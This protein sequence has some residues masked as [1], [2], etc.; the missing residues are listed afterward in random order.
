[1][2]QIRF[3]EKTYNTDSLD[4]SLWKRILG[5]LSSQKKRLI[6]LGILNVFIALVDVLLPFMNKIGIDV[7]ANGKGT[8]TQFY[9]FVAIFIFGAL[10]QA[11][12]VY[13]YFIEAG[14]TEMNMAYELR[15][16]L[17]K[18]LQS[19]SYSYFDVTPDGWLLSRLTSDVTRLSEILAWSLM[20]M[21]WGFCM[22]LGIVV[23]MLWTNWRLALLVL[24]VVPILDV[25]ARWFNIRI[26]KNYRD[27]RRINSQITSSFNEGITGAKTT[28]TLVLEDSNFQEFDQI[29]TEMKIKSIRAATLSAM[30]YP[31]VMMLSSFSI[32]A[33]LVYGGHQVLL[34]VIE[35]GTLIMFSDYATRFF[36]PLNQIS[37]LIAEL[38]MA[39]ASAERVLSLLDEEPSIVD[40]EDV[41][42]KYGNEFNLKT[43]N[44]EKMEGNI[45]FKNVGFHYVEGQEVLKDFNLTVKP[46]EM[47]ALVGETGSGKSTIV[48]LLCRFYEPTSG[49]ILIDGKDYKDRSLGWLHSQIGYVLQSP[50]LFSGTIKENIRFGNLNATDEEIRKVC[51]MVNADAFIEKLEGKYDFEVGEEGNRLSTGQKQLI[52]FARAIIANPGIF[53]LDEATSAVDTETEQIIQ[54]TVN[55]VMKGR[56]TFVVAHRLSTIVNADK[57]LV[58]KEG[59]ILE[60]GTHQELMRNQ[61]YYY[62]LYSNQFTEEQ[63]LEV[64]NSYEKN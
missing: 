30:F 7:F 5:L 61:G 27:V 14:H 38:Q 16:N 4:I 52:S 1:M 42:E 62:R 57:I 17:F 37:S 2:S 9:I 10:L 40:R 25:V 8:Q 21:A 12:M 13:F 22:M 18:K 59:R 39:Q 19:L 43:E 48:N 29:T 44:F 63:T 36:E 23:V 28:K 46:G 31:T 60:Q 34:Q 32:A 51:E 26:L 41:I 20:D 58:I 64:M 24:A 55:K 11:T 56:T 3:E 50:F 53:I 45:E 15:E 49:Q 47:I 54:Q 33:V 35:F 6:K